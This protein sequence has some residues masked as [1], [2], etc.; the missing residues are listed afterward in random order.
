MKRKKSQKFY[1]LSKFSC[2]LTKVRR[3]YKCI[4]LIMFYTTYWLLRPLRGN[5]SRVKRFEW[6]RKF[7]ITYGCAFMSNIL[8]S[9]IVAFKWE[10]TENSM[11]DQILLASDQNL[12]ENKGFCVFHLAKSHVTV[13]VGS[14]YGFGEDCSSEKDYCLYNKW[15]SITSTNMKE[16]KKYFYYKQLQI[17]WLQIH[18]IVLL[19]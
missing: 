9:F 6:F 12:L 5:D 3:L 18:K 8:W 4:K 15:E 16:K 14:C 19:Q 13:V 10:G 11:A 17:T 7:L 2:Y 1:S